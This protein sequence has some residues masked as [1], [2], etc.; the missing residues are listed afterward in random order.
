[1]IL[2]NATLM[3]SPFEKSPKLLLWG[4]GV[5]IYSH[6]DN[7]GDESFYDLDMINSTPMDVHIS[8]K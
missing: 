7:T 4:G 1:M 8:Y 3:I 2:N 5:I 6:R